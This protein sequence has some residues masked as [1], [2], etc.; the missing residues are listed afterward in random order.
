MSIT[1]AASLLNGNRKNKIMGA[2]GLEEK[3]IKFIRLPVSVS[4]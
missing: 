4:N 3:R 1:S 2:E